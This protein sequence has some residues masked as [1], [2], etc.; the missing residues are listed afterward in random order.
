MH[1]SQ[2]KLPSVQPEGSLL[3]ELIKYKNK[4]YE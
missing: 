2:S 1:N 3:F 4:Q